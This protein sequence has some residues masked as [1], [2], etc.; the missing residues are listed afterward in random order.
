MVTPAI[1]RNCHR[2]P[3]PRSR[4]YRRIQL[5]LQLTAIYFAK[6]GFATCAIDHQGH[7]LSDG[8]IAH[9]PDINPVIDDCI[10]FFDEFCSFFDPSLSFFLYS[11]SLGSAIALLIT[12]RCRDSLENVSSANRA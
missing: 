3:R 1:P 11:E 6:A 5:F 9:I 12:L 10:A 8:L 4:I 7:G 2:N